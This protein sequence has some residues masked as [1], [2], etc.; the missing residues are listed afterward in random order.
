MKKNV[1]LM[2][3]LMIGLSAWSQTSKNTSIVIQT[4]G[5]CQKCH[6]IMKTHVPYFKGVTDFSYDDA[7]AKVTVTYN[8]SK[9]TPDE[10]RK[11]ISSLGYDADN[12][13][14]DP[15]AREKLPACCKNPKGTHSG[16]SDHNHSGSGHCGGH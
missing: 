11:K 10:I 6:E 15:K 13:K 1:F 2:V 12:V 14:A 8:P 16:C 5:V 3:M 7:S 9:T 4:N